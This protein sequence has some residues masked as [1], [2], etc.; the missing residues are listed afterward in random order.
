MAIFGLRKPSVLPPESRRPITLKH[1]M[2]KFKTEQ[3]VDPLNSIVIALHSS[4][5]LRPY[6][7]V[8]SLFRR[9]VN[10]GRHACTCAA[11]TYPSI[12][13]GYGLLLVSETARRRTNRKN[14]HWKL[15]KKT[16]KRNAV[17]TLVCPAA[18]SLRYSITTGVYS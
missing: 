16:E 6:Q 5:S 13:R 9:C 15:K 11:S 1:E 2:H 10:V 14:K 12:I 17:C 8:S 3:I 7:V 4:F 18:R